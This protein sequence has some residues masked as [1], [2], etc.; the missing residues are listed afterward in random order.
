MLDALLKLSAAELI[1]LVIAG[2]AGIYAHYLGKI[3]ELRKA[4]HTLTLRSYFVD[5]V[6]ET[7][8]SVLVTYIAIYGTIEAGSPSLLSAALLGFTCDS[9]AN[10]FRDRAGHLAK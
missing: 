8:F 6:P 9:I 3:I 1:A 10:K 5:N 2:A 4:E 7:T